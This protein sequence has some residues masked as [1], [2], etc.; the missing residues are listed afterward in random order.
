ME[1]TKMKKLT[2]IF[3]LVLAI[4]AGAAQRTASDGNSASVQAAITASA[5]GDTVIIPAGTWVWKNE[6]DVGYN[7]LTHT[8]FI[9]GS[10]RG[11]T[12]L[13]DSLPSGSGASMIVFQGDSLTRKFGLSDLTIKY[14]V[15]NAKIYI[16]GT[17]KNFRINNITIDSTGNRTFYIPN[18]SYTY[19]V[20]DSVIFNMNHQTD[21]LFFSGDDASWHRPL[22]LGSASAIYIEDCIFNYPAG[23]GIPLSD[24]ECG[25][26]YCFRYNTIVNAG[27][28]QHDLQG[29]F[30]HDGTFSY[31]IYKNT[32]VANTEV[33][34][35]AFVRGGTGV[36][37]NNIA[38]GNID[39]GWWVANY[40]SCDLGF[41]SP[42]YW[43]NGSSVWDGNNNAIATGYPCK[44]QTGRSYTVGLH[45]G[46]PDS[47]VQDSV[48]ACQ[49]NNTTNGNATTWL[50]TGNCY[51]STILLGRDVINGIAPK[52]TALTYPH[53]LRGLPKSMSVSSV[54]AGTVDTLKGS[55]F[56]AARQNGYIKVDSL[57]SVSLS[58]AS[59]A[60]TKIGFTPPISVGTH[61]IFIVNNDF[62]VD[63]ST[64]ITISASSTT[65]KNCKVRVGVK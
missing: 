35:L 41:G 19:G 44:D 46:T 26:R 38:T 52:Y 36:I 42:Y 10:G 9:K 8:V 12:I 2:I 56:Q 32:Y 27:L 28:G 31:E 30:P 18:N 62:Q 37:F 63:S 54:V 15:E 50:I 55:G 48:P 3:L 24:A 21:C 64:T 53:P 25:S 65:K 49:W 61:K 57:G 40:R 17:C 4:G 45:A 58:I 11:T 20:F 7:G 60:N 13:I 22:S 23:N 29:D 43:C 5:N 59:W 47:S 16:S 14:G 39:A 34:D 6:V 1:Q 33:Y 51:G